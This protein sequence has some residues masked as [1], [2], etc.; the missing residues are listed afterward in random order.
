MTPVPQEV[1]RDLD[2]R[3]LLVRPSIATG[4]FQSMLLP[5][6]SRL[7]VF[8]ELLISSHRR[9]MTLRRDLAA[10]ECISDEAVHYAA[11]IR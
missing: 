3:S 8:P 11:S 7:S 6:C 10:M 5:I 1:N 4:A 9:K 2:E